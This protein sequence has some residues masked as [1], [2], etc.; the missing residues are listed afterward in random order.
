MPPS[1]SGES[2]GKVA[3]AAACGATCAAEANDDDA[4]NDCYFQYREYELEL[5]GLLDSQVVQERNKNGCGDGN[6]LSPGH[7]ESM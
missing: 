7:C 5:S 6:E 4:E 1:G 3:P 2:A